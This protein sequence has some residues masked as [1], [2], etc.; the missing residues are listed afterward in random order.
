MEHPTSPE[1]RWPCL[2]RRLAGVGCSA[3]RGRR[4][5]VALLHGSYALSTAWVEGGTVWRCCHTPKHRRPRQTMRLPPLLFSISTATTQFIRTCTCPCTQFSLCAYPFRSV[6]RPIDYPSDLC[7]SFGHVLPLVRASSPLPALPRRPRY[8]IAPFTAPLP[9]PRPAA[10]TMRTFSPETL[11]VSHCQAP[12]HVPT[13]SGFSLACLTFAPLS[14][15]PASQRFSI[16]IAPFQ[17]REFVI[18]FK[19]PVSIF[20]PLISC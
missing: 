10:G 15:R 6:S 20:K 8:P 17:F 14:P 9:P 12:F 2:S 16:R 1:R 18:S 4:P 3:W 7:A 13:G 19:I 11:A 5:A